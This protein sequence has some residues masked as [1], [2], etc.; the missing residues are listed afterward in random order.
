MIHGTR[1]GGAGPSRS[2]DELGDADLV[3]WLEPNRRAPGASSSRV[4]SAS[5]RAVR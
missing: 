3:E 1:P 5:G 4:A 2:L